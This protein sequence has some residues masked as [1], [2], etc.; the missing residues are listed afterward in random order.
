MDLKNKLA[1]NVADTTFNIYSRFP[2]KRMNPC[3]APFV[4]QLLSQS[5]AGLYKSA[6]GNKQLI[7]SNADNLK[8]KSLKTPAFSF[9]IADLVNK[10]ILLFLLL[11]A[12][13]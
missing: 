5:N 2:L 8:G 7:T 12:R 9:I 6:L 10:D 13:N 1:K 11:Q 3:A 4:E